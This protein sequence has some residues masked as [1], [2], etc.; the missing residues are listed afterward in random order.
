MTWTWHRFRP[1]A[2]SP[3][4]CAEPGC[5]FPR[6][7]A[8]HARGTGAGAVPGYFDRRLGLE[9]VAEGDDVPWATGPGIPTLQLAP[10]H[11]AT[12]RRVG[13]IAR[14]DVNPTRALEPREAADGRARASLIAGTVAGFAAGVATAGLAA[15]AVLGA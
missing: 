15:L 2:S 14:L 5:P 11:R 4:K 12:V 1:L 3:E 8:I 13:D 9:W 7:G 6:G 10:G